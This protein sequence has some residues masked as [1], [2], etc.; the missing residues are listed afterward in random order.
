MADEAKKEGQAGGQDAGK[1]AEG[2]A[3]D[4]KVQEKASEIAQRQIQE[5]KAA[6]A[7]ATMEKL[8][9]RFNSDPE[10]AEEFN[11]IWRGMKKEQVVEDD[12]ASDDDDDPI[13]Q[14]RKEMDGLKGELAKRSTEVEELRNTF[15]Y[16]KISARRESIN[17]KY[18]SKF[19]DMASAAGYDVNSDAFQTLYSD[20]LRETRSLASK[21]GLTAE[22][23]SPDPLKDYNEGFIKEAFDNVLERHKRSGMY[24]GVARKRRMDE[25]K[26]QR[27][28]QKDEFS[29]YLDPSKLKTRSDRAAALEKMFRHKFPGMKIV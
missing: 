1:V 8:E 23:G 5:A 9:E 21:F 12:K 17:G 29:K 3:D 27:E 22:D 2:A 20:I 11:R 7:L 16:D 26:R 4:K 24:D 13:V 14:M 15:G 19:K 10:F 25:E 18:D 28:P 6:K